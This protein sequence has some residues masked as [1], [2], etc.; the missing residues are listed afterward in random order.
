[1]AYV[2]PHQRQKTMLAK[3]VWA[4]IGAGVD[5]GFSD[6]DLI[7]AFDPATIRQVAASVRQAQAGAVAAPVQN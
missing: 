1:M 3:L 5:V 6:E 7:K 2:S 4:S